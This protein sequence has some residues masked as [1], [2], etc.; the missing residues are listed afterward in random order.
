M[1]VRRTLPLPLPQKVMAA[2]KALIDAYKKVN[3]DFR[4][5]YDGASWKVWILADNNTGGYPDF[6]GMTNEELAEKLTQSLRANAT[7]LRYRAEAL[8]R[9]SNEILELLNGK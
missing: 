7:T 2:L 9:H 3:K 6:T 5:D 8:L 4:A 1:Q